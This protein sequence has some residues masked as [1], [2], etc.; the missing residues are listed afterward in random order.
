[1]LESIGPLSPATLFL[2]LSS[3]GSWAALLCH[4]F[5]FLGQK[6][7]LAMD[8]YCFSNCIFRPARL[9]PMAVVLPMRTMSWVISGC[10][11]LG[12]ALAL[13]AGGDK[14]AGKLLGAALLGWLFLAP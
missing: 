4:C 10:R 11:Y 13:R 5:W 1:M 9:C 6:S 14:A 12:K 3:H 7:M 8:C 2:Q